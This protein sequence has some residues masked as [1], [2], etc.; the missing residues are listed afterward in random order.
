MIHCPLPYCTV[1]VAVVEWDR[2]AEVAVTVTTQLCGWLLLLPLE[3]APEP[4][5]RVAPA[6]PATRIRMPNHLARL[7]KTSGERQHEHP[8]RN[9]RDLRSGPFIPVK[10]GNQR[11]LN[12]H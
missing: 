2:A 1:I 11:N 12:S 9:Q 6:A 8:N 5:S 10:R 4:L 3:D 7:R